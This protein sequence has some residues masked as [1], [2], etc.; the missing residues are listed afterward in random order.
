[1]RNA[2]FIPAI[3]EQGVVAFTLRVNEETL[4]LRVPVYG[5]TVSKEVNRIPYARVLIVDGDAATQDFEISNE[6]WFVP[7]N[8]LEIFLG[9]LNGESRVFKGVIIKQQISI[10]NGFSFLEV[11]CRDL[12]YRMT[13]RRQGRYF[14]QV[15]DSEAATEL[16]K[17]SG[18]KAEV[19]DTRHRHADLVQH[20][21]TDW[22]FL[23]SR[24]ECNGLLTIVDDGVARIQAPD[25]DQEPVLHLHH[26]ATILEFDGGL[27]LRDQYEQVVARAWDPGAQE[28]VE[29][30]AKEPR[31][32]EN[33][34]LP[35]RKIAAANGDAVIAHR[36]GGRVSDSELQAWANARLLKDRLS[37]T[38]GRVQFQG[39]NAVKPGHIVV[40][41][42]FGR[43]FDGPVFVAAVHQEYLESGWITEIEFGLSSKW[44]AEIVNMEA[45]RAA[46]LLPAVSGLQIGLVTQIE[47]DPDGLHRVR[48]RLPILDETAG[49]V[50]ARVAAFDAGA[51][52]GAFFRP[53]V[54]DE[55]IVGFIHDDP[56]D[57]VVLGMLHSRD[58]AAPFTAGRDNAEKGYVSR[59][60]IRIVFNEKDG[61]ITLETPGGNKMVIADKSGG[62]VL[63]DQNGNSIEM[64]KAGITLKSSTNIKIEAGS[65]CAL[66]A[67]TVWKAVS[68]GQAKLNAT[69]VT[70]IKGAIVNI[71]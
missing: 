1:M 13:L 5:L 15:T 9:Y 44:F 28:I 33:G 10:R 64:D 3:G 19:T 63:A 50:W 24:M 30:A 25:F 67:G 20:D 49:G 52:R 17:A 69:G 65:E 56:R 53:E 45:P 35:G 48:V 70:E 60:G 57:A 38:C 68:R 43:R 27:E 7:G 29:I 23:V 40:L 71:N 66:Q 58:K 55:V 31:V 12:A 54:N 22:D 2:Q 16:L 62:I 51:G 46:G 32:K 18:M 4:P 42:G 14:E 39:Y 34:N 59:E 47:N 26:G 41:H 37:R 11:D 8:Q 61:S 6:K 36:H 21:C